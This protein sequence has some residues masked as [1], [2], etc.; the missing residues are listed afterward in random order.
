MLIKT[1][2]NKCHKFKSF[3]YHKVQLIE[4]LGEDV[5][6]VQIKARANSRAICSGCHKPAPCYDRGGFSTDL[7]KAISKKKNQY[8]ITWQKGFTQEEA[9]EV[10][11]KDKIILE[12]PYNDLGNYKNK[13]IK[14]GEDKWQCKEYQCRR[15]V[16]KKV[17][18]NGSKEIFYSSILTNDEKSNGSVIVQKML[19]RQNQEN[20][21]KKQR[22]ILD[23]MRLLVIKSWTI[24][25]WGIRTQRQ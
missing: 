22:I 2:L 9:K 4:R 14:Y 5:I 23:L 16:I 12:Y 7:M 1:L 11:I 13:I 21:F 18:Q 25:N 6:E 19:R 24:T 3:I 10:K 20:D 8:F 15:I 17:S